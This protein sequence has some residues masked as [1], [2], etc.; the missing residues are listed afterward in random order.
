MY[1][2]YI[3]KGVL[4]KD[5]STTGVSVGGG[6]IFLYIFGKFRTKSGT[7]GTKSGP[8]RTNPDQ[9]QTSLRKFFLSPVTPIF[10]CKI[11]RYPS[12]GVQ[13]DL[14]FSCPILLMK[15]CEHFK[16]F[17]FSYFFKIK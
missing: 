12:N 17:K 11:K 15:F 3:P 4:R 2:I 1:N 16:I 8:I 10:D 14:E 13:K 5:L 6:F 9:I 7:I